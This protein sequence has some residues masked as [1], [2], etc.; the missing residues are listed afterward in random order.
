M[1]KL[2]GVLIT[3]AV[4]ASLFFVGQGISQAAGVYPIDRSEGGTVTVSNENSPANQGK[5][6][7]FDSNNLTKWLI[8][9]NTGWIQYQFA[10]SDKYAI[11]QY[12]IRSAEDYPERDPASWTLKGSNDGTSW[13]LLDTQQNQTFTNRY[14]V[15]T[16][17]FSN[18]TLYNYY[19]FEF[20]NHSGTILQLAEIELFDGASKSYAP[21]TPTITASGENAPNEG[22]AQIYDGT[23]TTK[24]LTSQSSGYVRF[25]FVQTIALES[26]SITAAND[27]SERDPKNWTLQASNDGVSWTTIDSRSDENFNN[28]HQRKDYAVSS[29]PAAYRYY[30]F[31]FTNHSG[32]ILQ[33]GEIE[34]S[35]KDDMWH[36]IAPVIDYHNFDTTYKGTLINQAFSDAETEVTAIVRKINAIF[37]ANPGDALFGPKVIHIRIEDADG[38]A[39]A[40]GSRSESDIFISSQHLF[41]VYNSGKSLREEII[42]I[43]YHELTHVYQENDNGAAPGYMIEGIAD[44]VRFEVGYHDRYSHPVGGTWQGSYGTTGNFIRW[45]DEHKRPGFLRDINASLSSFDGSTWTTSVFSALAGADVNTLWNEYQIS[46]DHDAP[47]VP[48]GL[49]V[50][51][52]TTS[53][54]SLSWTPSTDNLNVAGYDV[55]RDNVKVGTAS[56]ASYTVSGLSEATAYT[57]FVKAVDTAGNV[58]GMSG[59]ITATTNAAAQSA[60]IYYKRGF[61]T[62]Y[63]HYQVDGGSWTTAPGVLMADSEIAGYS[64][65]T[66]NLGSAA[67]LTA[68]FNNGSGTWDSN[69]GQNYRFAAGTS[70]VVGGTVTSGMP[71]PDSVTFVVT[72]PSNTPSNASI[73]L[74]SNLGSWNP[75]DTNYKLTKN[76]N[77]T[78]SITL[79]VPA[80]TYIEYKFTKGTW[81]NEEVSSSGAAI[82]NRTLT[83]SGGAQTVNVTVARWKDQ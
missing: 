4:F 60:T 21:L 34:F 26:Y 64:K 20:N 62:P 63:I 48:T 44:A 81:A 10:G 2:Y 58:S 25:D 15:K 46:L 41:N 72:V 42:G 16:Y 39:S 38:V 52:K 57:F 49:A 77:G 12:T 36:E 78:Y 6:S 23:S 1:K 40:G 13:T 76:A 68:A 56:S 37:Y 19:R 55:Y 29:N 74:S 47:T 5:S 69:G 18:T 24:W 11:N 50:A 83:T 61:S 73:Y 71:K 67:G 82:G 14:E 66:I 31:N 7:A 9:N 22:V 70:T 8:F 33:V 17:Q 80:G 3:I 35:Y 45:I 43:L 30:Q 54:I 51:G 59:S 28:R 65:I 53:S 79:S 32:N 27:A 75:G